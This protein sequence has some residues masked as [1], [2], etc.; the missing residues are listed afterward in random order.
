ML[1]KL[2]IL[3]GILLVTSPGYAAPVHGTHMP[4]EKR[5]TCGLEGSF[6][7]DRNLDNDQGS[8]SG[9]RYFAT[10]SYGVFEWL[11]FDGKIGIGDVRW[12]RTAGNDDLDYASNFAGAYGF[13]LKGYE[14]DEWGIKSVAGFQHISVHPDAKDQ[15]GNKHETIIDE[16]QG[17]L[18]VS[19]D[20]GNF[21][22]YT[23]VRYGTVDFIKWVDEKDR[24]RIQ[25]EK[26]YGIIAGFDY[27][28]DDRTKINL[29]G[30][31]LDGEELAIGISRDF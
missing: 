13:R 9:D 12:D 26:Y 16:W 5:F 8:T 19:K 21:I 25:S 30:I 24:K 1:K 20:I 4:E 28:L 23:G 17:S 14:N 3:I 7:L 22:P 31:F 10:V 15:E 11:C 2:L 29:E 18:V 27:R 6:I